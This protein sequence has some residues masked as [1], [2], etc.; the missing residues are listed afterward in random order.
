MRAVIQVS[1]NGMFYLQS[2]TRKNLTRFEPK[3][4]NLG[5]PLNILL[6]LNLHNRPHLTV[7]E[8]CDYLFC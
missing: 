5:K 4:D 1:R 6:A 7:K 2:Q 8:C 3:T